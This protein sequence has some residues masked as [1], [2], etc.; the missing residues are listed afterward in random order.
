[1]FAGAACEVQLVESGGGLVKLGG[2]TLTLSCEACGYIIVTT[3]CPWSARIHGNGLSGS[4]A[5]IVLLIC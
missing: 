2:G 4:H 3:G 5:L 1:V